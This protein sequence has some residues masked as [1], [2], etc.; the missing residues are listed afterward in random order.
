MTPT[1]V[2]GA[3][4]R[5]ALLVGCA[6]VVAYLALATPNLGGFG[7]F[8]DELNKACPAFAWIGRDSHMFSLC[9][10]GGVPMMVMK[11][12]AATKASLYG[13]LWLKA[14]RPF[15]IESWRMVGISA[16][17]LTLFAF[18]LLARRALPPGALALVGGT[19]ILDATVL[20][21]TRHD[22]G[23][24]AIALSL[25]LLMLGVWLRTSR[26]APGALRGAFVLGAL[27]GFAVFD[28]LSSAALVAPLLLWT[29]ADG[30][31]NA[32]RRFLALAARGV[33]GAGPILAVNAYWL[34]AY[35]ELFSISEVLRTNPQDAESF[36]RILRGCLTLGGGAAYRAEMLGH[37]PT[38][39][40]DFDGVLLAGLLVLTV[41]VGIRLRRDTPGPAREGLLL[42]VSWGLVVLGL[43]ALPETTNPHHWA[44]TTPY[45]IVGA[46]SAW[47]AARRRAPRL[48]ALLIAAFLALWAVRLPGAYEIQRDLRATRAT[49]KWD[50]ALNELGRF[51]GRHETTGFLA[52]GWGVST[53]IFC[54]G[55][56]REDVVRQLYRNYEGVAELQHE[57]DT[58]RHRS[59]VYVVALNPPVGPLNEVPPRIFADL[60]HVKGWVQ[61]P[62]EPELSSPA[63]RC[64]KLVPVD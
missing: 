2:E 32:R 40:Q 37:P 44:L 6:T 62:L 3:S 30:R 33:L 26:T 59:A 45:A 42:A 57:L 25:R 39:L 19:L 1:P 18:I 54:F 4:R 27:G 64:V 5:S 38:L 63:L 22:W 13:P 50:P 24:V 10:I 60:A 7:A 49:R 43:F 34:F 21:G 56:G 51:A 12:K 48:A 16:V 61:A 46:A 52:A 31:G 41:A 58:S 28:K 35:G 9:R 53:Q 20:L 11:Y 17:A 29:L 8:Y 14:G 23:P 47:T 15:T 55:Q 36:L